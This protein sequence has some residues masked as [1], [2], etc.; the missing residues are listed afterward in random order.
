MLNVVRPLK[1]LT[2]SGP[3]ETSTAAGDGTT[4]TATVLVAVHPLSVVMV[5]VYVVLVAGSV[6]VGLATV[7]DESPAAGDQL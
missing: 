6:K 2:C 7:L 3:V 1:V 4:F 5:R